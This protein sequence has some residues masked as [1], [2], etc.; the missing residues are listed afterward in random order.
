MGDTMVECNARVVKVVGAFVG[1]ILEI[2]NSA[3]P[4]A[5]KTT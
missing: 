5:A 1:L 3:A 2:E 4:A